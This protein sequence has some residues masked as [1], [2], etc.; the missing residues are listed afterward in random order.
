MLW[1]KDLTNLLSFAVI[2]LVFGM[3]RDTPRLGAIAGDRLLAL[4]SS[5]LSFG[6]V[7]LFWHC[8][9]RALLGLNNILGLTG[10]GVDNSLGTYGGGTNSETWR[11]IG[12][13]EGRGIRLPKLRGITFQIPTQTNDSS[14]FKSN[15][16]ST[17]HY[18]GWFSLYIWVQTVIRWYH[19]RV[20]LIV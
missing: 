4:P 7:C 19:I 5:E 2:G 14:L 15:W 12:R 13:E 11:G 9:W 18:I 6:D 20:V 3:I 1:F 17:V 10:E 16:P 8:T